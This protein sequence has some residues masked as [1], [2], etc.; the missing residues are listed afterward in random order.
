ML[1]DLAETC[2]RRALALEP[3][4]FRWVYLLAIV[5]EIQG[6]EIEELRELFDRARVY[7]FLAK[8]YGIAQSVPCQWS[9]SVI[10][11]NRHAN[12]I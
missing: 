8:E 12:G 9:V 4:E 1:T 3:E 10:H 5:R 2:Y 6:A 11:L 7:A